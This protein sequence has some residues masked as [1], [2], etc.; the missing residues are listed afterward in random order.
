MKDLCMDKTSRHIFTTYS[1][2]SSWKRKQFTMSMGL[3]PSSMKFLSL[4]DYCTCTNSRKMSSI[5]GMNLFNI[6]PKEISIH[7]GN[8][9]NVE[10]FKSYIRSFWSTYLSLVDVIF[11][12]QKTHCT[13]PARLHSTGT[14]HGASGTRTLRLGAGTWCLRKNN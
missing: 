1:W 10:V 3:G 4:W 7:L 2:W 5:D 12:T 9:Q 6:V 8:T 11:P 13:P 14:R